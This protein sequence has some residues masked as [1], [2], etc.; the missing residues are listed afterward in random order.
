M[1][2]DRLAWVGIAVGQK[3]SCANGSPSVVAVLIDAESGQAVVQVTAGGCTTTTQ[4]S[5]PDQLESVAWSTVS[6]SSTSVT[7]DIPAC[8]SYVGWTIVTIGSGSYVQLQAAV[9]YEPLCASDAPVSAV[10]NLV[11]PVGSNDASAPP[12]PVGDIDNLQV[13]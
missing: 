7:V 8:G 10:V 11:V 1:Y 4:V 13:L 6:S 9:P 2:H 12:A 3:P 5:R